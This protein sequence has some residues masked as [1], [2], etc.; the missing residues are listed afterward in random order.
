MSSESAFKD[1]IRQVFVEESNLDYSERLQV[2]LDLEVEILRAC[3][4]QGGITR[5]HRRIG[6]MDCRIKADERRDVSK[7]GPGNSYPI[8]ESHDGIVIKS[9]LELH[10]GQDVDVVLVTEYRRQCSWYEVTPGSLNLVGLEGVLRGFNAH[11]GLQTVS[12]TKIDSI[13]HVSCSH[14]LVDIKVGRQ[15][16]GRVRQ[17]IG[18]EERRIGIEKIDNFAVVCGR[19]VGWI[20]PKVVIGI[21]EA[22]Q[23]I[24]H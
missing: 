19:A 5:G 21:G 22:A 18:R 17:R 10:A 7:V 12:A 4:L 11:T 24:A 6:S 20:D 16:S 8:T 14:A 1:W 9:S 15:S 3:R 13:H 23:E 2:M